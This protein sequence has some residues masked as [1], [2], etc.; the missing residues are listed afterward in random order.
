MNFIDTV[1]R[2]YSWLVDDGYAFETLSSSRARYTKGNISISIIMDEQTRE[3]FV[4]VK[5]AGFDLVDLQSMRRFRGELKSNVG[6]PGPDLFWVPTACNDDELRETVSEMSEQ[7]RSFREAALD[8]NSM[9]LNQVARMEVNAPKL[10]EDEP[11]WIV[12]SRVATVYAQGNDD[13]NI[14]RVLAPHESELNEYA[15]SLLNNAR[16]SLNDGSGRLG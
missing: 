10:L 5:K 7:L 16:R 8:P 13:V 6:N 1:R 15:L 14:V 2:V 12:A 4:G 3:L 9:F 11:A